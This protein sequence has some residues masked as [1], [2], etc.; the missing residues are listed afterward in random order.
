MC[1][2]LMTGGDDVLLEGW[3]GQIVSPVRVGEDARASARS[4]LKSG[5]TEPLYRNTGA[6]GCRQAELRSMDDFELVTKRIDAL[7]ANKHCDE[8]N[9]PA[10]SQFRHNRSLAL[11]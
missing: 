8:E 2:V 3:P 4:D 11:K 9:E 10:E 1:A 5:M 6:S 7:R